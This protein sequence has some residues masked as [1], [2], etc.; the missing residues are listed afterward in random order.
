MEGL[1]D[2]DTI[3]WT[4]VLGVSAE[5]KLNQITGTVSGGSPGGRRPREAV[6]CMGFPMELRQSPSQCRGIEPGMTKEG[7]LRGRH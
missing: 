4:E 1:G 7:L 5:T 3:R 6:S 2:R